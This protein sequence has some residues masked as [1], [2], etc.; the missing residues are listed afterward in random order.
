MHRFAEGNGL[1]RGCYRAPKRRSESDCAD[2][3]D[4]T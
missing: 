3:D 1:A 4:F 2:D